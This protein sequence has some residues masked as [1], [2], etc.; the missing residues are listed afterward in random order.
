MGK[1]TSPHLHAGTLILCPSP[2][3]G[4]LILMLPDMIHLF[5]VVGLVITMFAMLGHLL[6]GYRIYHM[7][8]LGQALYYWFQF[9]L[10]NFDR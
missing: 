8:D 10:F 4:T 5:F 6:Y 7:S 1:P 9:I 3:A 2:H